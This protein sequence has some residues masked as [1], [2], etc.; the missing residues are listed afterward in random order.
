M[1]VFTEF[2]TLDRLKSHYRA[3]VSF[4]KTFVLLAF[5]SI[6][7]NSASDDVEQLSVMF[8]DLVTFQ[9]LLYKEVLYI[10]GFKPK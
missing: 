1:F 7:V 5:V 6:V 8:I 9:R 2:V 4:C 10:D 3:D